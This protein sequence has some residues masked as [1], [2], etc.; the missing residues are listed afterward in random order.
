MSSKEQPQWGNYYYQGLRK[1]KKNWALEILHKL[2]EELPT[3][4][5]IF[6]E[7][8]FYVFAICFTIA[9]IVLVIFF[10]KIVGVKLKEHPLETNRDWGEPV[11]ANFFSFPWEEEKRRKKKQE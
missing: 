10:A 11:P 7:E 1:G 8:T 6:D 3:F 5:E 4:E 2:K 9:T